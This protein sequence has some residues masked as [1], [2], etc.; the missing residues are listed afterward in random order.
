[1]TPRVA[2]CPRRW[3]APDRKQAGRE[4][5][6]TFA[7]QIERSLRPSGSPCEVGTASSPAQEERRENLRCPVRAQP[8]SQGTL[9]PPKRRNTFSLAR[10]IP[11]CSPVH[12]RSRTSIEAPSSPAPRTPSD[13]AYGLRPVSRR[14]LQPSARSISSFTDRSCRDRRSSSALSDLACGRGLEASCHRQSNGAAAADR[15]RTSGTSCTGPTPATP[16]QGPRASPWFNM[17]KG[18]RLSTRALD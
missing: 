2:S 17:L 5:G 3:S 14:N 7:P 13:R 12:R 6:H 1:M 10:Y 9:S 18:R 16:A 15:A 8:Q 4:V 11:S